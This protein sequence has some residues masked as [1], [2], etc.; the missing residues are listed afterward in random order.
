MT[1]P[2]EPSLFDVAPP[3]LCDNPPCDRRATVALRVFGR[4]VARACPPC[5]RAEARR[6]YVVD[7]AA[8]P[9]LAGTI[10]VED[11]PVAPARRAQPETSTISA[12]A[13]TWRRGSQRVRMLEA[14]RVADRRGDGLTDEE[15]AT[16]AGIRAASS[17]WKRASELRD[18]GFLEDSGERRATTS[19]SPAVVWRMTGLGRR[20]WAA[21]VEARERELDAQERGPVGS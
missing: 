3:R 19:G 10:P 21:R 6:G 16:A 4:V 11:A 14:F 13:S 20:A 2:A 7:D 1:R 9:R 18:L 12:D 17:P 8:A 5:A 15:A